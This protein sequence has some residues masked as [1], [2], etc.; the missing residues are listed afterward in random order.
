VLR[1][2]VVALDQLGRVRQDAVDVREHSLQGAKS[3]KFGRGMLTKPITT[4]YSEN[5]TSCH[6]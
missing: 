2:V 6:H 1:R 4:V 3:S 5:I